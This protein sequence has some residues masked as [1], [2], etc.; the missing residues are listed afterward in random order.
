MADLSTETQV[1]QETP[2][3]DADLDNGLKL[4]EMEERA[5]QAEA[6]AKRFK[7]SL[8]KL[9]KEAAEKKRE[10]RAK[11]SEEEKRKADQEEEYNRLKEK[12]EA[13]AKELNH[14][15]A[16]TAY[17]EIDDADTIEK[18]IDAIADVD[19]PAI[20]KI[21]AD[22]KDKAIKEKEAEWKKS[23]P[24]GFVGSGSYPSKTKEEIMAITDPVERQK[25]IAAN[26]E[27]FN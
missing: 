15:R 23:R 26:L 7:A 3:V 22:I 20:M 13:D 24:A 10:E 12:A 4:A 25:A 19:H 8:D 17:K 6:D 2:E 18:L 9:M 21:I 14:L 1:T 5:K 11:M 27:L 16:I